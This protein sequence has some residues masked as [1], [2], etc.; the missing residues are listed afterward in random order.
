MTKVLLVSNDPL[1]DRMP[2]PAIRAWNLAEV[3]SA[4]HDVTLASTVA[5]TRSANSFECVV[6]DRQRRGRLEDS[7]DLAVI[8][9]GGLHEWPSLGTSD[10]P[11]VVD[12]YDPYH[13]ENLEAGPD[14]DPASRND[15]VQRMR[16]AIN[17]HLVRGDYFLCATERQRDFWLGSLA[18]VGRVNPYLY[19]EDPTLSI[20]FGVVPFGLPAAKPVRTGSGG[21]R[22]S[23]EG[24]GPGDRVILWGGG[25]YN[26]FDPVTLVKSMPSVVEQIPA[27]KLVFL[28][29]KHPNPSIPAMK[30]AVDATQQSNAL[31][32]TDS[33][34]FFNQDWVSYDDRANFLLEADIGV[35]THLDHI[36]TRFSFRTRVLDYL[37]ASL[38]MVLTEGDVLASELASAGVARV[39]PPGDVSALADVLV[40][41]LLEGRPDEALFEE[42]R[43]RFCWP[44]VAEP[45]VRFC[46]S[47]RRAPDR[48]LLRPD[49]AAAEPL[50]GG[51]DSYTRPVPS[52][53]GPSAKNTV[54]Q[55]RERA[56]G[57]LIRTIAASTADEAVGRVAAR[58]DE[59]E[60]ILGDQGDAADEVAE[61]IGRTLT[62]L[63]AEV[64]ALASEV[65]LL[66]EWLEQL[67]SST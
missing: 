63:S 45:L 27:A 42:V 23:I 43:E 39:V 15:T 20:M 17:R 37:W 12:L 25:I 52:T 24:V 3:L 35:S 13:L 59:V 32:L 2:G 48:G 6:A 34:V 31:G 4:D 46:D 47:P 41:T 21:L 64:T 40:T 57:G 66:R 22:E 26:W 44:K 11:L 67:K 5:C 19:D 1:T 55:L 60:R 36:E 33:V 51:S 50:A 65:A 7:A 61:I 53:S 9:A 58:I 38:P 28:G 29:M 62:R 30:A 18:S 56:I 49:G 10:L 16:E 8:T 14:E 54:S